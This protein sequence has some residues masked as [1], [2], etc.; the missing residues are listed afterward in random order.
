M[1]ILAG[2]SNPK[3]AEDIARELPVRLIERSIGKFPNGDIRIRLLESVEDEEVM[4]VQSLQEPAHDYLIEMLLIADAAMRGGAQGITALIPW[5]SYSKQDEVFQGGEPLA[6]EVLAKIISSGPFS[7]IWLIDLHN[8]KIMDYFT[9]SVE[10]LSLIESFAD[11][12]RDRIDGCSVAVSPDEGGTARSKK[13]AKTLG[14]PLLLIDK[15]RDLQT[16]AVTM[17][18]LE[19]SASGKDCY[20]FDDLILTGATAAAAGDFL[21]KMGAKSVT[22][23]ATVGL[24]SRGLGRLLNSGIDQIWISD[25]VP[26]TDKVQGGMVK[27]LR[28]GS[29]IARVLRKA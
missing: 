17:N 2:S 19:G 1:V 10:E 24:F 18:G 26:F 4:I 16:G 6:A 9:A 12:L 27:V 23:C 25:A 3:L 8:P 7:K 15:S 14:I 29:I 11:L 5:L 28:L 13:F 20:L 22:F 21:K